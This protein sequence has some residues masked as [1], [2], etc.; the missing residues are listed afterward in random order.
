[1]QPA[2]LLDIYPMLIELAGTPKRGDLEGLSLVPQL[3]EAATH[4]DRPAITSHNQGNHGIRSEKWRY[5]RYADSTEEFYDMQADPN[6]WHNLAARPEH[7][8]II[9]EHK[10]WLPSI[11]LPPA[12]GSGNRV[13]TY[14]KATDQAVWEGTTVKRTDPIPE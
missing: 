8:A 12:P 1:M 14:D 11:D 10:K 5:I 9:D 6:E 2:E 7:A 4:R 13:L 3:K